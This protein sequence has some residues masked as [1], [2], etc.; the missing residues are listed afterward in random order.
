[1]S[2]LATYSN[3][4][5]NVNPNDLVV[6]TAENGQKLVFGTGY[7][8]QCN[9]AI[10]LSSN[11]IG[12]NKVPDPGVAFDCLGAFS[13]DTHGITNITSTNVLSL[14]A[15]NV[16][17]AATGTFT[18]SNNVFGAVRASSI[19]ASSNGPN[20]FTLNIGGIAPSSTGTAVLNIGQGGSQSINIGGSPGIIRIGNSNDTVTV[21]GNATSIVS[22]TTTIGANTITINASGSNGSG[23]SSGV[24][25]AE[26]GTVTGYVKTTTDRNGFLFKA[27]NSFEFGMN[28]AS[29]SANFNANQLVLNSNGFVG[30]GT[31]AP[32]SQLTVSGDIATSGTVFAPTATITT[33]NC[34][35][36]Y[37]SQ[38][39]TVPSVGACNITCGCNLRFGPADLNARLVLSAPQNNDHQIVGIG[40]SNHAFKLQCDSATTPF[41]FS[42]GNNPFSST[43]LMRLTS[44]GLGIGI[45]NP[46]QSLDV[47][48]NAIVR[49]AVFTSVIQSPASNLYMDPNAMTQST[50]INC[51][52]SNGMVALLGRHVFTSN[53]LGVGTTSP[54]YPLDVAGTGNLA[55]LQI[56]GSDGNMKLYSLSASAGYGPASLLTEHLRY[57]GSNQTFQVISDGANAGMSAILQTQTAIR[58][59]GGFFAGQTNDYGLTPPALNLLE[60]LTVSSNVGIG[61]GSPQSKLHVNT[62]GINAYVQ[63]TGDSNFSQGITLAD[64]NTTLTFYKPSNTGDLRIANGAGDV[65]TVNPSGSVGIGTTQPAASFAIYQPS[66]IAQSTQTDVFRAE[67]PNG[68][69]RFT[70]AGNLRCYTS[71]GFNYFVATTNTSDARCKKDVVPIAG[72]HALDAISRLRGVRF[73]YEERLKLGTNR[74]IGFVAQ[75][76]A[77]VFPEVIHEDDE[78]THLSVEYDKLVPILAEGIKE[79]HGVVRRLE[80][81]LDELRAKTEKSHP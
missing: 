45:A 56:T 81:E 47:C 12:I 38:Q 29:N 33:V 51:T 60:R 48:S 72:K 43:E 74:R 52:N 64:P 25:I 4:F 5:S 6:R 34:S 8:T 41:V 70:N 80:A 75:E 68:S 49:G 69:V 76:V 37:I 31:A 54:Q 57:N 26:G 21:S 62:T 9:A 40:C 14:R 1:M 30:I 44:T 2:L 19:D 18:S 15:S 67:N 79:L 28:L 35:N 10:Y 46:V 58:M 61:T 78:T 73:S 23:A 20:A 63:V 7:G 59:F 32:S 24:L 66:S 3:A 42:Q 77:E 50:F 11:C 36:L 17:V 27:P 13:V 22:K 71:S 65:I 16:T 53:A 39:A 55:S